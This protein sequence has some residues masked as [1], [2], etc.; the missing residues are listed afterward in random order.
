MKSFTLVALLVL[1]R[2]PAPSRGQT[3]SVGNIPDGSK[4][5]NAGANGPS[6]R[7]TAATFS[8]ITSPDGQ[9]KIEKAVLITTA[10]GA[11]YGNP[12]AQGNP[13]FA[14]NIPNGTCAVTV[15]I[16]SYRFGIFLPDPS[17]YN[18]KFLAQGNYGFKGGINWVDLM[19]G[20]NYNMATMSTDQGVDVGPGTMA[21]SAGADGTKKKRDWAYRALQGSV[22]AAKQITTT[23]YSKAISYSYYSGCS[24]GGRQ[25]L[26]QIQL[27][28]GSFDGL[29]IGSPA[30][31]LSHYMPWLTSF[32]NKNLPQDKSGQTNPRNLGPSQWTVLTALAVKKCDALGDGVTDQ[33]ISVETCQLVD[34]DYASVKCSSDRA[35]Q[36]TCLTSGQIATAKLIYTNYTLSNGTSVYPAPNPG[37]EQDFALDLYQ[38]A[39]FSEPADFDQQWERYWLYDDS[40]WSWTKFSDQVFQDS[41]DPSRSQNA[42]AD[43]YSLSGFRGKMLLYH[44]I[45]DGLVPTRGSNRYYQNTQTAM[46]QSDAQLRSWF[47]YFLVPGMNHCWDNVATVAPWAFGGAGSARPLYR[48]G[49]TRFSGWGVP[50]HQG[51][52][53]YDMLLALMQW[54]EKGVAVD[55]VVATSWSSSLAEQQRPLCPWPLTAHIV[56]RNGGN[57]VASN[58]QCA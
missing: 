1:S 35:G 20:A 30:W 5:P 36:T 27:D 19:G 49:D 51:D 56:N 12:K 16:D 4:C 17:R 45:A 47:R 15:N 18:G 54:V 43:S 23:Y 9:V 29:L 14:Y 11:C 2:C 3:G 41:L 32:G 8:G 44:G 24:T 10:N 7:C 38:N 40:S 33:V 57:F 53:A 34:A 31:Q 48:A 6:G 28:Q 25:G 13:Q 21:W 39:T 50:G 22:A 26:K 52:A 37:G 42:T 55:K 58:W 46:G